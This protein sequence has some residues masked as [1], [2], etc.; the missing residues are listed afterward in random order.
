MK[1]RSR[2]TSANLAGLFNGL[3]LVISKS[4]QIR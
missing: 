3:S 2:M 1:A 4:P